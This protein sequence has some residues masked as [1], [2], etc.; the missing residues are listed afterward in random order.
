MHASFRPATTADE[1]ALLEL[2]RELYLHERMVFDEHAA[3][4]AL[5][6]VLVDPALGRAVL[7]EQD[8]IAAGYLVVCFGW[9][10]EFHGRDAFVDELYVRE[11]FRGQGLGGRALEVAAEL[12]RASGVRALHLEVDRRN[13]RAQGVYRKAGFVDREYYLMTRRLAP[14]GEPGDDRDR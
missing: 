4:A 8:G 5:R 3:R 6:G 11:R 10:L 2:M 7:I 14:A 9:S 13:T 12:C 1:P